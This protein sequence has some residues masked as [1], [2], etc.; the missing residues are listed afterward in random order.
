MSLPP[1]S[2]AMQSG[3]V[4]FIALVVLAA[5]AAAAVGIARSVDSGA[6]VA[7][8]LAF[9]RS[10]TA[11]AEKAIEDARKWLALNGNGNLL[12]QDQGG[13]YW[14]SWHADHDLIGSDPLVKDYN[15]NANAKCADGTAAIG[16]KNCQPD[17][18][19]NRIAW[20]VHRQCE[21]PGSPQTSQCV[22]PPQSGSTSEDK[23]ASDHNSQRTFTVS[24]AVFTVTVMVL[25]PANTSTAIQ[26]NLY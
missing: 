22:N 16:L 23:G 9:R 20:V 5:M 3:F 18:A 4:M 24:A 11:S 2:F 1:K 10:A 8:N 12:Y 14:S 17:I 7:G 21:S 26:A 13:Y 25:G 15:W 6:L 19:G